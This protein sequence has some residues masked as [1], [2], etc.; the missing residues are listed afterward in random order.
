VQIGCSLLKRVNVH[1]YERV[2]KGLKRISCFDCP[3]V[4]LENTICVLYCGGMHYDAL[5]LDPS[6]VQRIAAMKKSKV[7]KKPMCDD[8]DS[9]PNKKRRADDE[10]LHSFSKN[11]SSSFNHHHHNNNNNNNNNQHRQHLNSPNS[12]QKKKSGKNGGGQSFGL[13][14]GRAEYGNK[15]GFMRNPHPKRVRSF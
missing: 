6:E 15:F 14:A 8:L 2:R 7:T 11:N 13:K 1:V 10:D 12:S 4:S 9:R 3:N 5:L